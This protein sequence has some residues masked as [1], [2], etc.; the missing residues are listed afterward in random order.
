MGRTDQSVRS[1]FLM[2]TLNRA[3]TPGHPNRSIEA[4]YRRIVFNLGKKYGQYA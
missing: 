4:S 1:G 3:H 2:I